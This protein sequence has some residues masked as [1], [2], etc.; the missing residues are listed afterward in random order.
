[1][2]SDI[3]NFEKKFLDHLRSRYSDILREIREKG[4]ITPET[5]DKLRG[6]LEDFVPS[7]GLQMKS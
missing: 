2:T 3:A 7:A 4:M 6:I 1:M 5:D